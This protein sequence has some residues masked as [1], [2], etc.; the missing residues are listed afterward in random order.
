MAGFS[1]SWLNP[2]SHGDSDVAL[3]SHLTGA[4]T[5]CKVRKNSQK[6]IENDR[7][8]RQKVVNNREPPRDKTPEFIY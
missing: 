2:D 8:T 3:Y 1:A 7:D 6:V 5:A 4:R